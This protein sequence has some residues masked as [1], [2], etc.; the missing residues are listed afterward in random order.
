ML[1]IVVP[2]LV[3]TMAP[4]KSAESYE[5]QKLYKKKHDVAPSCSKHVVANLA[6]W[7]SSTWEQSNLQK[8]EIKVLRWGGERCDSFG[9]KCINKWSYRMVSLRQNPCQ[10]VEAITR[11]KTSKTS[12]QPVDQSDQDH[13]KL[14]SKPSKLSWL[15]IWPAT[16][17]TLYGQMRWYKQ[18]FF[19]GH[20]Q[21]FTEFNTSH[22]KGFN[23]Q[24]SRVSRIK[25]D[26]SRYI[27]I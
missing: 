20:I 16:C 15:T 25:L 5:H 4:T 18:A 23:F 6:S 7:T 13:T 8:P 10:K 14:R 1:H 26:I 22:F 19:P 27:Y 2:N 17:S 3:P 21:S 9:P 24:P 12:S 11:Q